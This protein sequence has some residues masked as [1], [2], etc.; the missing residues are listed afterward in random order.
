MADKL[1]SKH[2]AAFKNYSWA[3]AQQR[4]VC[5]PL[6]NFHEGKKVGVG[7]AIELSKIGDPC[8]IN[9]GSMYVASV[10]V[11]TSHRMTKP[12]NPAARQQVMFFQACH[13]LG[14]L[15]HHNGVI[16]EPALCHPWW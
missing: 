10:Q 3:A 13:L 16:G 4:P 9:D 15:P 8:S 1:E 12:R 5:I 6:K 7:N 2:L 14:H 11:E